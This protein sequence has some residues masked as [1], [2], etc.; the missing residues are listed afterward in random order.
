MPAVTLVAMVLAG[1]LL[2]DAE[3]EPAFRAGGRPAQ[4]G[5]NMAPVNLAP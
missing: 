4:A 1:A 3:R 2:A 5:N